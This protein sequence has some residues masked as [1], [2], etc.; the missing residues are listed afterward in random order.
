[1]RPDR[2]TATARRRGR[3]TRWL[4]AAAVAVL[5]GGVLL[6]GAFSPAAA[7]TGVP[8]TVVALVP[9][10]LVDC[11][12]SNGEH[13]YTA[14]FGYTYSGNR[15][16]TL[17]A[18]P[19]NFVTPIELNGAQTVT[20]APGT[21]HGAFRITVQGRYWGV[22]WWLAGT[23]ATARWRS[24]PCGPDVTL[25]TEGNGIGPVL[26]VVFSMGFS[27]LLTAVRTRLKRRRKGA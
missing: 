17:P 8:G 19:A 1:M 24:T 18:G 13:S 21:H 16:V 6:P 10:P 4:A 5:L 25:P 14:V 9:V 27:F 12:I 23:P 11:V 22:A 3:L 26:V 7:R 2:P 20:F 15:S